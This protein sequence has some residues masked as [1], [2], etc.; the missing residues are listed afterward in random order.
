M[1]LCRGAVVFLSKSYGYY[2][3]TY[4]HKF[5]LSLTQFS[6]SLTIY[7]SIYLSI[8]V[9]IFFKAGGSI[10]VCICVHV[11]V[12]VLNEHSLFL[13][14]PIIFR[15]LR[16]YIFFRLTPSLKGDNSLIWLHRKVHKV[17]PLLAG[18]AGWQWVKDSCYCWGGQHHDD[19]GPI[20]D[21]GY[22]ND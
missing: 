15:V 20:D 13:D 9:L 19:G 6:F 3:I 2:S 12:C 11:C 14:S 17:R 22:K 10:C 4:P 7:L 18:C 8:S 16:W 1:I 5:L 21:D